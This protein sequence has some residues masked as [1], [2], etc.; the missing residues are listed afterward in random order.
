MTTVREIFGIACPKC[1]SDDDLRVVIRVVAELSADGTKPFGDQEWD[2]ES[3]CV[4]NGC[5]FAGYVG[6]FA[7]PEVVS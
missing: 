5:E 7:V 2:D 3:P 4:C 1:G 6:Q